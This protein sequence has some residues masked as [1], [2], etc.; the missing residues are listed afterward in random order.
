MLTYLLEFSNDKIKTLGIDKIK[1][2]INDLK[3]NLIDE[4]WLN[5]LFTIIREIKFESD[6]NSLSVICNIH[7][8]IADDEE[9][10]EIKER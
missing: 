8:E 10:V 9:Y 6:A 1:K 5:G 4:N 7:Y 2:E 3:N